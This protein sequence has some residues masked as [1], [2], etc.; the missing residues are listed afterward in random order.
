MPRAKGGPKTRARRKR[1]LK[2][3]KGFR[4]SRS[5]VFTVAK[6][7]VDRALV[8]AYTGRKQR[9]RQMRQLWNI[10]I[11]AAVRPMGLSYSRFIHGLKLASV[12]LDRRSLA[13]LANHDQ[14]AFEAV[15]MLA[16][17]SL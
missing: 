8:F 10:Q 5:R 3:A 7:S 13:D 12:E 1:V 4:G 15:V 14:G 11:G 16:K 17:Q 9:K 6:E 2:L